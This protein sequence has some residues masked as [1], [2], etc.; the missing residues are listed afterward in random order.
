LSIQGTLDRIP[1]MTQE[2]RD[3]VRANAERWIN[4]GTDAQRAD[5]IIVLKALDDAVTAEHQALYDEL[6]GMAAAERVA[7]AFTRQPL[8]DTEVK[9][10]EALLANPGSTSRA[11]SA[12]C[13]WKAQ[14]W[15]M[16]FG[17]MCKSREIYLWPAPPS[18]TRQDEQMMTGILADLDESNNTWTMKPDI[19]KA[20]RAMGLGGKT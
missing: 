7:T 13:G 17:T 6:K 16:H 20:F 14:T 15:H 4:E 2:S 1:S 3:K 10:I 19:E 18:S 9:I 8:T 11:L 12:A 5:A